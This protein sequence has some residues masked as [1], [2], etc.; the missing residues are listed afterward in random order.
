MFT[1]LWDVQSRNIHTGR[2]QLGGVR[3]WSQSLSRVVTESSKLWQ[4]ERH[5]TTMCSPLHLFISEETIELSPAWSPP[6]LTSLLHSSLH[7]NK[8]RL[9]W[10]TCNLA[11]QTP[12]Q[13]RVQTL[14]QKQTNQQRLNKIIHRKCHVQKQICANLN[15][16]QSYF[17]LIAV[18]FMVLK[19]EPKTSYVLNKSPAIE[20]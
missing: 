3:T 5:V 12:R 18:L 19:M 20:F 9:R 4:H 16:T 14:S 10:C 7:L 17:S 8:P 2:K 6:F 11:L 1:F 13:G 15:K